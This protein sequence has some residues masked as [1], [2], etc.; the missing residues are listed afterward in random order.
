[1]TVD[2]H[3]SFFQP[4]SSSAIVVRR[5]ETLRGIA[6][7]ADYLN[8]RTA[9]V[10]NQVDKSLQTT[11]RLDALKLWMTLRAMGSDR[12]GE[13]FDA[14]VDR[15]HEAY[16]HLLGDP[17]FEALTPPTLSTLLFRFRPAGLSVAGCDDLMPRLRQ[18]LFH[19][20]RAIVAGTT[21][22]GHHWLKFT[23]LNPNTTMDDLREVLD[24]IREIGR[25]MSQPRAAAVMA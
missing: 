23:L 16:R 8:P 3:K 20:G 11:R 15:A 25:E 24:L 17:D 13:M 9:T 1:M 5:G 21:V 10:P 4:V 7:H 19:G 14:V 22:G 12:I 6:V 18:R 2:F